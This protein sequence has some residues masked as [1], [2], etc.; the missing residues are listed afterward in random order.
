MDQSALKQIAD[1]TSAIKR[2]TEATRPASGRPAM[3]NVAGAA[4]LD[5][6]LRQHWKG[7]CRIAAAGGQARSELGPVVFD[8]ISRVM[9]ARLLVE[10]VGRLLDEA[11]A[12]AAAASDKA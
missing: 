9:A 2:I 10:G 8:S 4:P 6:F 1:A 7:V 11:K 3:S 5:A 12:T